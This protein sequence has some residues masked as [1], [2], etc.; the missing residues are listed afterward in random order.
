LEGGKQTVRLTVYPGK[1]A[2]VSPAVL[3]HDINVELSAELPQIPELVD[4]RLLPHPLPDVVLYV[5]Q[6]G[7][8]RGQTLRTY[9]S[10]PALGMLREPLPPLPLSAA[11]IRGI[12]QAAARAAGGADS[13]PPADVQAG[14]RAFGAALFDLLFPPEHELRSVYWKIFRRARLSPTPW[15][16]LIISDERAVL[17][18]EMVCP[19]DPLEDGDGVWYDQFLPRGFIMSHWIGRQRLKLSVN[20]PLGRLDMLHY[21]QRDEAELADWRSALG[22]EELVEVE[23][24]SEPAALM[25]QGSPFYGVHIVRYEG[26]RQAGL[27]TEAGGGGRGDGAGPQRARG[28]VHDRHLDF[29]LRRPVVGLSLV[30]GTSAAEGRGRDYDFEGDWALPFMRAGATALVGA[31]WPVRPESDRLFYRTFYRELYNL[32][33]VGWAAWKARAELHAAFPQRSDW[34][35]YACF[36][37]PS[38]KPYPVQPS[39]GFILF[40]A[41][42]HPAEAPFVAGREYL[43]RASY[44]TEAP[45]WY[46]GRLQQTQPPE[47]GA[48]E[49]SVIV[50]SLADSRPS[51]YPLETVSGSNDYHQIIP[52][53]MPREETTLPVLVRFQRGQEELRTLTLN[54]D[55]V[56][57]GA[58]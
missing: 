24:Q 36:G 44:R 31:R 18:W 55:V 13:A 9:L 34:L 6:E 51:V 42:N 3:T 7:G 41:I 32:R 4:P 15:S 10:C 17:P 30:R 58:A 39:E 46:D 8:A 53:L 28:L 43:F 19:Y 22:G 33:P 45:V 57:G 52:L 56:T 40:E 20:A 38:C 49:L 25:R 29:S 14:L 54:L 27:I 48:E 16:W 21:N 1:L 23:P 37:H 50:K 12:R 11:D 5:T 2:G 35:A 47:P 26:T